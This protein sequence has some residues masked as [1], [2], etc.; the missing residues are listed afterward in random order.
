MVANENYATDKVY[1]SYKRW[2]FDL[3]AHTF[4]FCF[5]LESIEHVQNGAAFLD[6]LYKALK[7]GGVLIL[8]TPNQDLMP[9]V[10]KQHKFH[11]RHYTEKESFDLLKQRKMEIVA[12]GG[13]DVYHIHN[14]RTHELLH[15]DAEVTPEVPGQ[16]MIMVARK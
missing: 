13:Q 4:D 8:S 9:I 3:P 12:W 1:F 5:C 10:P 14:D 2:P 7:P 15:P 6:I 16:F 11:V